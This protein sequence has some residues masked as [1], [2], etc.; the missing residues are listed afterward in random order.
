[1]LCKCFLSLLM[2]FPC[3]LFCQTVSGK[4]ENVFG[5]KIPF[6]N[7]VTKDSIGAANIKEFSIAKNGFYSITL[8]KPYKTLVLEVSANN[9]QKEVFIIENLNPGTNYVHDIFLVKDTI[10]KLKDVVVTA[11]AR[12]FQ[13][14][15]DTVS[16]NVAS[17]SD[18]S[19]RKIQDVIK[20]LPGI[21]LNEKTGEI[22][23]KGKSVETVKLDG[24]DLFASNYSLGTKNIN[25]DM[26]EQVQAIENYSNN[27]LLKGIES[28]DKVALNLT[29]K[30]K[31]TDYSGS[32]DLGTGLL[33]SK[34]AIDAGTTLL[35]I[36]SAYKSFATISYN[37]IGINNSPFDYFSYSP[38]A[39]QIKEAGL[40]AK[41]YIPDTYFT[42]EVDAQRSN[43]NNLI[44]GSY[45][46]V[47]KIGKRLSLKSNLYYLND[48]ILSEQS[49]FAENNINGQKFA[50]SDQ[51]SIVKKPMQ[52][53]G[54][55]EA[56]YN[57]SKKSLLEY[58]VRYSTERINSSNNLFQNNSV[59]YYTFL[60]TKDIFLKQTL[61]YTIRLSAKQALQVIA[62]H[63]V[64]DVPQ[65]YAFVPAIHD[66]GSF[67]A[68]NQLAK[69]KKR[70]LNLQAQLLGSTEKANYTLSLGSHSEMTDFISGVSGHTNNNEIWINGFNNNFRYTRR[71]VYTDGSYK[72]QFNR[73]SLTPALTL[74]YLHQHLA[75]NDAHYVND[76]KNFLLEPSLAVG[77]KVNNYSALLLTTAYKQKPFSED[78]LVSNPV[79]L[80]NRIIR[81]NEV[82]LQLQRSKTLSLLYFV[83]NLYKQFQLNIGA[84]YAETEGNFFSDLLV[85]QDHTK[86]RYFFLPEPNKLFSINFMVEK[87]LPIVQST[88]RLKNNYSLQRYKN[89]VN[90]STLRSNTASSI[91]NEL[92]IKTAFDGKLNF[93]TTFQFKVLKSKAEGGHQF[94]NQNLSNNFQV[95][96][97]PFERV[98]FV[99]STDYFVPDTQK[100]GQNYLFLDA[101]LHYRS[102][103]KTYDLR[104]MAKNMTN[105]KSL[106]R[107]DT[108]DYS[109]TS[110]E[111]HLLPRQIVVSISR[112][113]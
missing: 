54:D 49:N 55:I 89:I 105:I 42:T 101:S 11:K 98:L 25:V 26:V 70:N 6:A 80:S 14:R 32:I 37:N 88:I 81:L 72:F 113:F 50:T 57:I 47:F 104:L 17:Y 27:P 35:G 36:S 76:K 41:K 87:Y 23:Y 106:N 109:T 64:N 62:R 94:T 83:S 38:N 20:K 85:Q 77:Y 22:K 82:S 46:A 40:F 9:Y 111:T 73:L 66:S 44:F 60:G 19:E 75:E 45:N 79:Y 29:L 31:K 86:V 10:V 78:Y 53:R 84:F 63:A 48:R 1:M 5:E 107:I 97:K 71:S 12:P 92:F 95:I 7:V 61:G 96:G 3:K 67:R 110:L 39:E 33:G 51:Y 28:G 24:D 59:N 91:S 13:I 108:N 56:K 30:K 18:G 8:T 90:N 15:G 65:N 112:S 4:I 103:T 34:A 69:F 99:V 2:V 52:Y 58:S 93:E 21:E 74:S 102:K 43:I 68:N 100:P 16:Y